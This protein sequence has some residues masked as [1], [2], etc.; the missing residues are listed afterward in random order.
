LDAEAVLF[1]IILFRNSSLEQQELLNVRKYLGR[2]RLEEGFLLLASLDV[3]NKFKLNIEEV[4]FDR[5]KLVEM[6]T[7]EYQQQ[8]DKKWTGIVSN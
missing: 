3:V 7:R 6:V 4:P 5:N 2:R 1:L 8:F